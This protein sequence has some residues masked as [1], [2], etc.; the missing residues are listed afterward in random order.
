MCWSSWVSFLLPF[1]SLLLREM[2]ILL[3]VGSFV[4][5]IGQCSDVHSL[6]C[7]TMSSHK[8]YTWVLWNQIGKIL[9]VCAVRS[10]QPQHFHFCHGNPVS[11]SFLGFKPKNEANFFGRI[12]SIE[13]NKF[14]SASSAVGWFWAQHHCQIWQWRSN[15]NK[16]TRAIFSE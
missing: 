5:Q 8:T 4:R 14:G 1:F 3:A 10:V 15:Q 16:A 12:I 9:S 13:N 2:T 11:A 7:P 6:H